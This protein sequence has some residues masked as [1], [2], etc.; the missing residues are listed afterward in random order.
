MSDEKLTEIVETKANLL[1]DLADAF[2]NAGLNVNIKEDTG[3]IELDANY[4]EA[5]S[6]TVKALGYSY[7]NPVY[8]ENGDVDMDASRR[9]AF[10][11]IINLGE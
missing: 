6:S 10:R 9:V 5:L 3:E 11:F 1:A 2:K 7:D 8:D 4:I